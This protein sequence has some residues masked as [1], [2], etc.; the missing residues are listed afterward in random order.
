MIYLILKLNRKNSELLCK[1]Q[2]YFAPQN[3]YAT[4]DNNL[5][6]AYN[7]KTY[8]KICRNINIEISFS[9]NKYLLS[10]NALR[11]TLTKWKT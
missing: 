1:T 5:N 6:V 10:A 9:L 8:L 7:N 4:F 2:N 11:V 3:Y